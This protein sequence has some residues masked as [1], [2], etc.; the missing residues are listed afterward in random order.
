MYKQNP[1]FYK[2]L[3]VGLIA[4]SFLRQLLEDGLV[5]GQDVIDLQDGIKCNQLFNTTVGIP[6]LS[7]IPILDPKSPH[8]RRTYAEP[9]ICLG[10]TYYLSNNW[11]SNNKQLLVNWL[12]KF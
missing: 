1:N 3:N 5:A 12:L 6:V 10:T 2:S 4:N 7:L 11:H 8:N 9:I